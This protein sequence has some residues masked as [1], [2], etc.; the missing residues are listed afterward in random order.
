M[1]DGDALLAAIL[2]QPDEDV[3]RLAYADWLDEVGDEQSRI[4]AEFIRVQI[5]MARIPPREVMPDRTRMLELMPRARVILTTHGESWL[6]PLRQ[7]GGPLN[8]YQAHGEF[9]RGFVEVVWMSAVGFVSKAENLFASAPVRELRV[10]RTT[11]P[12]F[13]ALMACPQVGKLSGLD[14]SAWRLGNASARLIVRSRFTKSLRVLRLCGCG[15]TNEGARILAHAE[16]DRSLVELDVR[17]NPIDSA[18]FAALRKR[19]GDAL[20]RDEGE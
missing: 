9:R 8:S 11:L 3:P 2:A 6:A 7:P 16:F 14:V 17:R 5:E 12:E 18:G 20:I 1:S 19:F 10:N 4:R 13:R 15:L